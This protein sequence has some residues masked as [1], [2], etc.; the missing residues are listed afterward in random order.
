MSNKA[1]QTSSKLAKKIAMK[2]KKVK[3]K[4]AVESLAKV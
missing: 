4:E 3:K 1:S 2:R